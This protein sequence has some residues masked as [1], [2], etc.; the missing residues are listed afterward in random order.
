MA[1][2]MASKRGSR[3]LAAAAAATAALVGVATWA[4][5]K[6]LRKMSPKI[7]RQTMF[8]RA[9]VFNV[10]SESGEVVRALA[11]GGAIQSGT[12]LGERRFD[13]PLEYYRAF[14]HVFE[15]AIPMR[16]V[17]MIGGGAFA[18]PKHALT[19][20]DD[21][22]VDVAEIDPEIVGIARRHFF[23]DEL[24]ER[25]G[26]RLAIIEKDGLD[27][28]KSA[29]EPYDA[30][31]NDSFAGDVPTRSLLTGEGLQAVR[32]RLVEGGLYLVNVVC[33]LDLSGLQ[34]TVE[35]LQDAFAHVHVI[36][37]TDEDF[38]S[39]D[40]YLVIGTDGEYAFSGAFEAE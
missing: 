20:H 8:G 17:L 30:I 34:S 1:Q 37:C 25:V 3:V 15:A 29:G 26:N 13:A 27:V 39:D 36:P 16:R 23:L 24:E 28:L 7:E 35:A 32:G 40:N 6:V 10:E 18:W 5:S 38:S 21:L 33:G 9:F 31:I 11:V 14:D 19:R 22:A 2:H 12:Y 4:A